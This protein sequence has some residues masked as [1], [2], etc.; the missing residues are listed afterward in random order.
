MI[1]HFDVW[2]PSKIPTLGGSWWFVTFIDDCTRMTWLCLMKSKFEVNLL[3]QKFFKIIRTQYNAQTQVLRSD[4]GGEYQC[5]ELQHFLEDNG[6]IHQTSYSNTPQ[7]NNIAEWENRNL[8]EVVHA[9]RNR[10]PH[11]FMLLGWSFSICSIYDQSCSI[12]L[13]RLPNT[14]LGSSL[15]IVAPKSQIYPL[16]FSDVLPS[17]IFINTNV[18][19]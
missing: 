11:A 8:L 10:S 15:A 3:F 14:L 13:Y 19:S 18:E 7:Q 2:G 17:P 5:S 1:I 6:S 12:S 9:F 16:M 4:N